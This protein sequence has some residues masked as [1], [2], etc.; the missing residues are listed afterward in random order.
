VYGGEAGTE[1][2]D[3][4]ESAARSTQFIELDGV[5]VSMT[6]FNIGGNNF[7]GLRELAHYLGYRVTY[8]EATN[9]AIIESK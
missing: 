9:A 8:D 3:K 6:A 2:A 4:S 5:A 1:F 7:F